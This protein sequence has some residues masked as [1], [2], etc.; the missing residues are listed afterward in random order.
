MHTL[1]ADLRVRPTLPDLRD[2]FDCAPHKRGYE[3]TK[4]E[5]T[6]RTIEYG[7]DLGSV[8]VS[9][10]S[11]WTDETAWTVKVTKKSRECWSNE[12][13][14]EQS[15]YVQYSQFR[16]HE[17]CGRTARCTAPAHRMQ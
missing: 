2:P 11:G 5:T 1:I 14:P 16:R 15:R 4:D 8:K 9:A 3:Y 6:N 12:E 17:P 13:G 7:V 10:L